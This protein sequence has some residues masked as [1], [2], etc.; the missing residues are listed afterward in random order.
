MVNLK[1]FTPKQKAF[2]SLA[3]YLMT[4]V[5]TDPKLAARERKEFYSL[6]E[7]GHWLIFGGHGAPIEANV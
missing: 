6:L 3:P 1:D 7:P 4:S 5:D 2:N